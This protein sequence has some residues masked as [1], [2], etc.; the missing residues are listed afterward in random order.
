LGAVF[1]TALTP[2]LDALRVERAA[3]DVIAHAGK[4]LHAAAA[5]HHDRMFLKIVAFAGDVA[6]D[7][8]TVGQAHARHFTQCGVRLFRRRRIDPCADAALLWRLLK[9]RNLV[10]RPLGLAR[11]AHELVDR[12]HYSTASPNINRQ[13]GCMPHRRTG[14][15]NS[16]SARSDRELQAMFN[17]GTEA[18]FR[19]TAYR[20]PGK[21]G[22]YYGRDPAPS[23]GK[24][25][26][27]HDNSAA[28]TQA[29]DNDQGGSDGDD[30]GDR[31]HLYDRRR[32]GQGAGG[33]ESLGDR[34]AGPGDRADRGA[35]WR[36]Q[37]R[38]GAR[39]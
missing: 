12:R 37:R 35:R 30:Q 2:V 11:L 16:G 15:V 25:E 6:G 26:K 10:A 22:G 21:V 34:T 3:D 27:S 29:D 31:I 13:A 7:F 28:F 17:N 32:P 36:L 4:V 38:G 20:Q 19:M 14:Q 1:G 18:A 33:E 9:R 5:D 8:E 39:F 23:S 24:D